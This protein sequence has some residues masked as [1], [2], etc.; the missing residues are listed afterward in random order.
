MELDVLAGEYAVCRL[1]AGED[2]PD[3]VGPRDGSRLCAIT[4]AGTELSVLCPSEWL[5]PTADAAGIRATLG[6]LALRVRGPL[7]FVLVG[8]LASL[9]DPLRDAEVSVLAMSTFDTDYLLFPAASREPALAAL[10]EAGHT[11][12]EG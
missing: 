11:V 10:R 9:L 1:A 3:W 7:D 5:P 4:W 6:W 12:A 2:L 8:V